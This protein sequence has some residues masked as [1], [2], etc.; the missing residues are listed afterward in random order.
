MKLILGQSS[1][2]TGKYSARPAG[3]PGDFLLALE[4]LRRFLR[5]HSI[6]A[7]IKEPQLPGAQYAFSRHGGIFHTDVV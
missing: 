2:Y 7:A 1:P 6:P 4:H 3:K 5:H